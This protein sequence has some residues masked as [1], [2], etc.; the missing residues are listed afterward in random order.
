MP[1]LLILVALFSLGSAA[2]LSQTPAELPPPARTIELYDGVAPGSEKWDWEEYTYVT[3]YGNT[4]TRNV[5]KPTLQYYPADPDKACGTAV[6]IAP[7]GGFTDL[8]IKYEGVRNALALNALGIDVFILKYRLIYTDPTVP[9]PK[10][11]E[12][13]PPV[14]QKMDEDR[15]ILWG[16]QTGQNIAELSHADARQAVAWVRSHSAEFNLKEDRVGII[17]F[18]AG[19]LVALDLALDE[20]TYRPAFAGIIYGP[21]TKGRSI[22][23]LAPPLFIA[24]ASDD[25]WAGPQALTLYQSW[26]EA[27]RPA[28]LHI[29]QTG[30]HG[31]LNY[32]GGADFFIDRFA[33]WLRANNWLPDGPEGTGSLFR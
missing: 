32:G 9:L 3:L 8:M 16:P 30:G 1:R 7:G 21:D 4:V 2:L 31:F 13:P 20:A 18:S 17:G 26:H 11:G 15:N 24:V 12:P 19:A 5:V 22:P 23:A 25:P 33:E 29:F 28:E 27:G 10:P 6:I 14:V